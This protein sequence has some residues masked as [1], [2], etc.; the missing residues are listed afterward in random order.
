MSFMRQ[1]KDSADECTCLTFSDG[2]QILNL[3]GP[4]RVIV[5]MLFLLYGLLLRSCASYL[6][7][8]IFL[9]GSAR[10]NA[11]LYQDT[12]TRHYARS[13][14]LPWIAL[15]A[16]HSQLQSDCSLYRYNTF[17]IW[18]EI[19]MMWFRFQCSLLNLVCRH[20]IYNVS[21]V[22]IKVIF[23]VVTGGS[24]IEHQRPQWAYCVLPVRWL[25]HRRYNYNWVL[26][27]L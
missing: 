12:T 11:N 14:I 27:Y 19:I 9:C 22:K 4:L 1:D 20:I 16:V 26:A 25:L 24:E 15:N 7:G 10:L 23:L 18:C 5:V 3:G 6:P 21:H 13:L 8:A 17:S 2:S